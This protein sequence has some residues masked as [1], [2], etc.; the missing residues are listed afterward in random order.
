MAGRLD[1]PRA[2]SLRW[3]R[4]AARL[5]IPQISL[6][7]LEAQPRVQL[8]SAGVSITTVAARLG[9]A[10]AGVTLKVYAALFAKDDA[11][12]AAAIDRRSVSKGQ[13]YLA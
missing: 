12:A 7:Q 4:A 10:N 13:A 8:I 1:G 6:A 9:H 11:E 3:G 2:F 5:G